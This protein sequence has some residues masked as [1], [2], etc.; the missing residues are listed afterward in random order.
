MKRKLDSNDVP[1]TE[2]ADAKKARG[3]TFESLGLDPRLLQAIAREKVSKPTL[4]Q[5]EAILPAWTGKDILGTVKLCL[6]VRCLTDYFIARSKT[7]S[8]KTAAYVL[9]ILHSIL[10]QKAV[11]SAPWRSTFPML[12]SFTVQFNFQ[13]DLRSDS[14]SHEGACRASTQSSLVFRH[15]LREGYPLNQSY[16]ESLRSRAAIHA[17]GLPRCCSFYTCTGPLKS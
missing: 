1:S 9:P 6:C 16:S 17:C 11:S 13:I 3:T 10:R 7:G 8:G 14:C 15:L 12:I 4:V 2:P 5:T